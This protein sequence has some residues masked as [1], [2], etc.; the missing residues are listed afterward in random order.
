VARA[1]GVFKSWLVLFKESLK[2]LKR[3]K[4]REFSQERPK[5]TKKPSGS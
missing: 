2:E 1:K 5:L 3:I 4:R